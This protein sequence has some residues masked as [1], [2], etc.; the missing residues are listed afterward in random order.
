MR[1]THLRQD[2]QTSKLGLIKIIHDLFPEDTLKTAYSIQ[3][4]IYC[5]LA[6]SLL[7]EREVHLIDVKLR[8]W[9]TKDNPIEFL[10]HRDGYYHYS[11]EGYV[12]RVVYPADIRTSLVEPFQII[13]YHGG[14]IIDFGEMEAINGR[15]H[16][17][18]PYKLTENYEKS[19]EWL[20]NIHT[21]LISDVNSYV[22]NGRSLELLGM[23]EALQEKEISLIADNILKQ[24]RALRVLLISGPS[25]SGKTSF[26]Q[27]LSTQ[28]RVDG[29]HPIPLSLDDYYINRDETPLDEEGNPD[30]ESINSIDLK[31][32]R[33]DM[34]G[35]IAG[36][37]VETP[38][39]DFRTG[40]RSD[41]TN[42]MQV[43]EDEILVIEGIHALNPALLPAI[44]RNLFYKIYISA[45]FSLNVDMMNRIP[46]TEVRLMRR[47]V[48]DDQFRNIYPEANLDQ[49]PRVRKGEYEN[50][51]K[52]QEESDIMFNS[53]LIYELNVLRPFVEAT[54]AKLGPDSKHLDTRDR[55]MNLLSFVT[56]MENEK[57]PFNSILREFIGGS[58]YF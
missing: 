53:S 20:R 33:E 13:P 47:L 9:M 39:Y 45:L 5:R 30:Y 56:P 42:S 28:L 55:L 6:N 7:S 40:R 17:T 4:G 43:A 24:R 34:S 1:E 52:F 14:F 44:S 18:L 48:R 58:I 27:R 54:L 12:A 49:W 21:E 26:A 29:L 15:K 2:R 10:Y 11:L 35:L 32:L 37:R 50:I 51:F 57:V 22:K 19:Q 25:S 41:K 8:E 3:E 23:A 46:T 31:Q 16:L 36:K 38:I